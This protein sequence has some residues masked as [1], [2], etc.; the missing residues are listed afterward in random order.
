MRAVVD[1]KKNRQ[2]Q[3][4]PR[5]DGFI[6]TYELTRY[7]WMVQFAE[8]SARSFVQEFTGR[9]SVAGQAPIAYEMFVHPGTTPQQ[10]LNH[11]SRMGT[12]LEPR[13]AV[14]GYAG[15]LFL[16]QPPGMN[17]YLRQK[18]FTYPGGG[19]PKDLDLERFLA[20][21][22]GGR[23]QTYG[24]ILRNQPDTNSGVW[25]END[26]PFVRVPVELVLGGEGRA[27]TAARAVVIVAIPPGAEHPFLKELAEARAN[28][29]TAPKTDTPPRE[30][31]TVQL[32][33][34]VLRIESD[35]VAVAAAP[36]R[37]QMG[38]GVPGMPGGPP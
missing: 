35:L 36:T 12:T 15:G 31:Q 6:K 8:I 28:A 13:T 26:Q 16:P 20:F 5:P 27:G 19:K 1:E 21:W 32:P 18:M 17:D 23:I 38:P 10:A 29:A 34:R 37:E 25:F 11:I 2:W 4:A 7:G 9:T 22:N 33:W 24:T 30:L 14:T 3:I